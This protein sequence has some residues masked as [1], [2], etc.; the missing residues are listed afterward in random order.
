MKKPADTQKT[1]SAGLAAAI[2]FL[3][4]ALVSAGVSIVSF[5]MVIYQKSDP[6]AS[7]TPIPWDR[8]KTWAVA[9]VAAFFGFVL[10]LTLIT[11]LVQ[12]RRR[13]RARSA[14]AQEPQAKPIPAESPAQAAQAD[15]DASAVSP[16]SSVWDVPD[17]EPTEAASAAHRPPPLYGT[18]LPGEGEPAPAPDESAAEAAFYPAIGPEPAP[19]PTA[20]PT[21]PPF[22]SARKTPSAAKTRPTPGKKAGTPGKKAGARAAKAPEPRPTAGSVVPE[23]GADTRDRLGKYTVKK[24]GV[25]KNARFL[26]K[27]PNGQLLYESRDYASRETC[28]KGIQTFKK[29]AQEGTFTIEDDKSGRFKFRLQNRLYVCEGET[30]A[31]PEQVENT[32]ASVRHNAKTETIVFE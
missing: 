10:L 13:K 11:G 12:S 7:G 6:A 28:I 27:A 30:L 23:L 5:L 4:A 31:R 22:K 19:A 26:L 14:A 1:S 2:L 32:I 16:V 21:T 18:Q 29:A 17:Q 20:E 3:L 25:D 9:I 24:T 8:H 15:S